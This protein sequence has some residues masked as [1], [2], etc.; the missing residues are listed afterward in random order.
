[1]K[2]NMCILVISI[3][4]QYIYPHIKFTYFSKSAFLS[5]SS[6]DKNLFFFFFGSLLM[7]WLFVFQHR[8][9]SLAVN[10]RDRNRGV[11]MLHVVQHFILWKE[12][13]LMNDSD[14]FFK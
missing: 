14:H 11:H 13:Y 10:S 6:N 3:S 12:I 4:D 5:P 8:D 9:N 7:A 1:M 2:C